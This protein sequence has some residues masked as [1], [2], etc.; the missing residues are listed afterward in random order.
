MAFFVLKK[1]PQLLLQKRKD[2]SVHRMCV[3][4]LVFKLWGC[5]YLSQGRVNTSRV[6]YDK[7]SVLDISTLEY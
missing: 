1:H 3:S 6:S 2:I 7:W 4:V 5:S